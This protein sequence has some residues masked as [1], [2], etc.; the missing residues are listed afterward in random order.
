MKQVT[1][2]GNPAFLLDDPWNVGQFQLTASL[3]GHITR[4]ETGREERKP[5]GDTARLKCNF[6]SLVKTQVASATLR[7]AS[8]AMENYPVL[9]PLWPAIR[10]P[11]ASH[12]VSSPWWIIYE[13]ASGVATVYATGSLPGSPPAGSWKVPLLVG[14]LS[15]KPTVQAQTGEVGL[16]QWE[17]YENSSD[18]IDLASYTPPTGLSIASVSR[19]LF[20]FRANWASPPQGSFAE[21]NI[22]RQVIGPNVRFQAEA[23]FSQLAFR[24]ERQQ[25]MLL[26]DNAWNLFRF[27][28]DQLGPVRPFLLQAGMNITGLVSDVA[29][30]ATSF[31]VDSNTSRGSNLYILLDDGTQRKPLKVNSNSAPNIW[32]LASAVGAD[33]KASITKI[34]DLLLARFMANSLTATFHQSDIAILDIP[35]R[36]VP[37]ELTS[38]SSETLGSDFGALTQGAFLYTFT[39]TNPA[40]SSVQR[41]CD[42]E[43]SLTNGG[44]TWDVANIEHG[45]IVEALNFDRQTIQIRASNLPTTNPLVKMF[46]FRLVGPLMVQIDEVDVSGSAASNIRTLFYGEVVSARMDGPFFTA[47]AE[48]LGSILDRPIPRRT[49]EPTCMWNLYE[50]AP[51]CGVS[52][53]ANK[54]L[55]LVVSW[56]GGITSITINTITLLGVPPSS[57]AAHWFAGGFAIVNGVYVRIADSTALSSGAITITLSTPIDFTSVGAT[58]E[59]YPGCDH[60]V[61]TCVSKFNNLAKFGGFPLVP[62]GNPSFLRVSAGVS[63]GGKK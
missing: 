58:V 41:F 18:H 28:L 14:K 39:A 63:S 52:K 36:E 60:T 29:S 62:I 22:D 19:S 55:S 4:G 47:T 38:P 37:S 27:W 32:N 30:A 34:H 33:F 11:A 40:T 10:T 50:P 45:Q 42:F 21:F 7:T 57:V 13:P 51:G 56:S 48:S 46:P 16:V 35:F 20:P 24:P 31:A 15:N 54:Y 23:Y 6:S 12:P 2:G 59:L 53:A 8:Q 17:F 9:C 61:E 25:F 26:G 49:F 5:F 43:R 3:P 44:N 1:F